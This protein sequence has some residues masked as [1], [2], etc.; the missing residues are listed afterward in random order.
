MNTDPVCKMQV[1]PELNTPCVDYAG[2]GIFNL[3]LC[4]VSGIFKKREQNR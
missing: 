1:N 2:V 3:A 4:V